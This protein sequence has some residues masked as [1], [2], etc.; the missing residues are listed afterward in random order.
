MIRTPGENFE[1]AIARYASYFINGP[2]FLAESREKG[3]GLF[4]RSKC[5][6]DRGRKTSDVETS[7]HKRK[8]GANIER[9]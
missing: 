1:A 4:S 2:N 6:V 7:D 9:L 8:C 5:G 3:I